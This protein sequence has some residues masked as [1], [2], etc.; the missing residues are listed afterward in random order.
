ML[1]V[2]NYLILDRVYNFFD[3]E[4]KITLQQQLLKKKEV[5]I[6]KHEVSNKATENQTNLHKNDLNIHF[7][8]NHNHKLHT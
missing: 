2:M 6:P 1:R 7:I 4:T 3:I 8:N 5:D